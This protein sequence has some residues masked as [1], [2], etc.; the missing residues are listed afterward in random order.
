M[1]L[2]TLLQAEPA[3][4]ALSVTLLGLLVGSFLNVVALR[5]P[6]MM[7]QQWHC[8][9]RELLALPAVTQEKLSLVSPRSRCPKCGTGIKPWQNIPV[10]SWLLLKGKCA[11]CATPISIQ[12]PLVEAATGLLSLACALHFGWGPQLLP[13]LLLTWFLVVLTVIDL[14]TMLLPDNLTLPLL[15]LGL[16]IALFGVFA[17]LRSAVIGGLAGYLSLWSVFHLFKLLTGKEGMGFGDF[18]LFAALGAWMGWQ[19]LPMIILLSSVVGAVVGVGLVI[20][21][22]R[23]RDTAIPFGPYLAG[24]GWI[25]LL[26]GDALK[27]TYFRLSG[28]Q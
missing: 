19:A 1:E 16:F 28:L 25:A 11:D 18:K 17:D 24:A 8:E 15:W 9:C 27:A 12:Y 3:L 13:A 26:W 21:A 14:R 10:V 5:L 4:L 2:F 23:G 6:K 20:A 7:E 22:R